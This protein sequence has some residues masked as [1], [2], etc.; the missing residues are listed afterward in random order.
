LLLVDIRAAVAVAQEK[1]EILTG[2]DTV[3]TGWHPQYLEPPC[4][5][6]VAAAGLLLIIS[7]LQSPAAMVAVEPAAIR[8]GIKLL[9][10]PTQ[11]AVAAALLVRMPLPQVAEGLEL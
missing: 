5:M 7:K 11:G 4:F 3:V 1:P 10:P 9:E 2:M 8:M 6:P